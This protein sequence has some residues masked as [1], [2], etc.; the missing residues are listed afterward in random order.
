MAFQ[1]K[2][3]SREINEEQKV[4]SYVIIDYNHFF[5]DIS[6][7]TYRST[8]A[9]VDVYSSD[10]VVKPTGDPEN[11][12]TLR[13]AGKSHSNNDIRQTTTFKVSEEEI[14]KTLRTL[15]CD[16]YIQKKV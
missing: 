2:K 11:P 9:G 3:R 16:I 6:N 7:E 10:P 15:R 8:K 4:S 1:N 13:N 5:Q 14:Q 12:G